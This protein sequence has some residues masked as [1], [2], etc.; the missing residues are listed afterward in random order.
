M[1]QSR[2]PQLLRLVCLCLGLWGSVAAHAGD[3]WDACTMLKKNNIET[4]FA[5]RLFDSG[6]LEKNPYKATAKMATVSTCT[7]VSAG[8]TP[9]E[10]MSVS[11]KAW[12]AP[13]DADGM[14]SEKAKIGAV[15][16]KATPVDV[17]GLGDGAYWIDMGSNKMPL[18]QLNVFKGKRNWLIYTAS[19]RQLDQTTA[20]TGLIKLAKAAQ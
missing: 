7:Y 17:A 1:K 8:A 11:L 15:T 12:R 18:V 14:T 16:I 2:Q 19:G 4:A 6:Q 9:K 13:S 3:D 20:L 5:P 10:R